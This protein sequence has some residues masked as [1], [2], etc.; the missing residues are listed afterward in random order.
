MSYSRNYSEYLGARRCCNISSAGPQ[1]PQ[2]VPGMAGP[3]GFQGATGPSGG[4]QGA[5]G[6]QGFTGATGSVGITGATGAQ[7]VT[8]ATGA[9]GFTG[10][11]GAQGFTGATGATGATGLQG[12]TG[13]TGATGL[14]GVTGATGG[15]PWFS[16]NYIGVTGPGYTGTG[17]TGDAMVF[18]NLLVTGGI[19]TTYLALTPQGSDPLPAGLDGMWIETGGSLRVQKM[20]MDDF[21]GTTAGYI[22][23]NPITNP[24]ITLSDGITPTEINVV[25]LNNN[26]ILLNDFSGTGTTTSFTT[27]NL[28]QTTTGPTTIS[29]T[30]ADII[31]GAASLN[32]LQ[33]VLDAGSTAID[34]SIT[35]TSSSV[36]S[37][38]ILSPTAI[39]LTETG[40][41][42]LFRNDQ[43]TTNIAVKTINGITGD[44]TETQMNANTGLSVEFFNGTLGAVQTSSVLDTDSLTMSNTLAGLFDSEILIENP[45]TFSEVRTTFDDLGIPTSATGFLKSQS[46][47]SEYST[48]VVDSA[49][50][51]SGSKTL[52]TI[53]GAILDTDTAINSATGETAVSNRTT[54]WSLGANTGQTFNTGTGTTTAYSTGAGSTIAQTEVSFITATQDISSTTSAQL[55][56]ATI[57]CEAKNLATTEFCS[58]QDATLTT[59]TV[60]NYTYNSDDTPSPLKVSNL[61]YQINATN[62]LGGYTYNDNTP[63]STTTNSV[64]TT[65]TIS[66]AFTSITSS[67]LSGASSHSL[68]LETPVSGDAIIQHTV[69]AGA[70]RNLGISTT[71]NLTMTADNFD[72]SATRMI[73]PSLA[74]T[75][76]LDYNTG[77][78]SIVN[79]SVGGTA[80]PLLVL[81]N[82][83]NTAGSVAIETYKN[84]VNGAQ[85][86]TIAN[87]SMYAKDYTGAKT[88]FA[89]I[90]STITNSSAIS[91]NDGALNIWAA[92]N[93]TISNVFTFNGADNEN[94]SFR[95]L[96]LT[97]N[98]LKT[99]SGNLTIDATASTGTG[100]IT[101]APK[102]S[103]SVIIPSSADANDFIRFTPSVIS[104]TNQLL[105][106]VNDAGTGFNS[107]INMINA[108][109]SPL[110][111][112]KA[113]FSSGGA[114]NKTIQVV[115][116][117]TTNYNKITAYDGQSNNPFQIDTSGYTNGSIE[118]KVQDTTGD[119]ILTG[120]NLQSGSANSPN[121]YLR[122]KI[123]GAY[124]KI[125]LLDD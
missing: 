103:A 53:G 21:S 74:S 119:I 69:T 76:Y 29:A 44:Y 83:N 90:N 91:G 88:E 118:L 26:A 92:V 81:Q 79:S 82:N 18:G 124:Y 3:I 75:D 58:R 114:I 71:G 41:S 62:A 80:N 110:I 116:D 108:V 67:S 112:L 16:T 25:T 46:N 105:M 57:S 95:P 55:G 33:K 38:I 111:E 47:Q 65:T 59:A 123:N 36:N 94:N 87:W 7:G 24:Q 113:D 50:N 1:G 22:D 106:S 122:I 5:T 99:S 104:N 78:L 96:D 48:S 37:S 66:T 28:S 30:W 19:D 45:S 32:T 73:M 40:G 93:G 43:S 10:A 12:V 72:L 20:R 49:N 97:G 17:Y 27:T 121:G 34:D 52:I 102:G 68:K 13:S 89:R 23:I 60:S 9:Q 35:L 4:A 85:N 42:T 109:N 101:L 115:A 51:V 6:A 2:G 56:Q 8:G 120:T 61:S 125:A 84:K 86:D 63:G 39:E 98:A 15:T 117:G 14:Q 70:S 11:T 31:S 54:G 107:T 77:K 100:T 64:G